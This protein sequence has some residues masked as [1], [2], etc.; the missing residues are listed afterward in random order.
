MICLLRCCE[1]SFFWSSFW[2]VNLWL[3]P[4]FISASWYIG[5]ESLKIF[6]FEDNL[7][8]RLSTD[9]GNCL[10]MEVEATFAVIYLCLL[11]SI[12]LNFSIKCLIDS[13]KILL[14]SRI[15]KTGIILKF[16]PPH[17]LIWPLTST[18][19]SSGCRICCL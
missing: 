2:Y 15:A 10:M 6:P 9:K 1:L 18:C 11:Y 17:I 7:L 5:V 12:D 14:S 13:L 16:P 8:K 19:C 3:Q 4:A